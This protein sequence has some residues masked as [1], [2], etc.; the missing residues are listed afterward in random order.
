[1]STPP[2]LLFVEANTTGTGMLALGHARRLGYEPVFLTRDPARYRGLDETGARI[3]LCDTNDR[4]E[5]FAAADR[6][7]AESGSGPGLAGVTT[8]SDFYLL[9]VA[10]L[11]EHLGLP[12]NSEAVVRTCRDKAAVREALAAR[13]IDQPAFAEVSS[14]DQAADAVRAVGLPCVVKPVDGSGSEN[15]RICHTMAQ[16][17]S[18]LAAVLAAHVNVRGQAS[19]RRALV[20]EY[21]VGPELS[22]EMFSEAGIAHGIGITEKS[23]TAPPHAVEWRHL[24]PALLDPGRTREIF[25]AVG[26]TLAAVGYRTGPSHTEIRLGA[27]GPMLIEIN[28]RLAGGMIPELVRLVDGV[29]LLEQQVRCAV[30]E[31]A[32]LTARR[33]AVAGIRFLT[34]E[35]EGVV[36]AVRGL[37]QA[38]ALEH[39]TQV[40]VTAA[41]GTTVGP[42]RD[43]YGRLGYAIA[44]SP[45]RELTV[46]GLDQA[47]E[48]LR[49][50]ITDIDEFTDTPEE[51]DCLDRTA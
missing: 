24:Y 18:Q 43:A 33:T 7:A 12:G 47:F 25:A 34:A 36:Q 41:A 9:A 27:R 31:K 23:V 11:A 50:E 28:P 13:G 20:E 5:L 10:A 8:T 15:V 3:V 26:A 32:R 35:R 16:A 19:A 42:P 38:R 40:T 37:D 29:D 51:A 14:L 48:L 39:I 2:A 1:M 22:V 44:A 46:R 49:P 21:I 30:G 6:L 17:R 45:S 4:A